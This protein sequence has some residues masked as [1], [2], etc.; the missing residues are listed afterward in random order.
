MLA[1][2]LNSLRSYLGGFAIA[3][4][5][6]GLVIVV[7]LTPVAIFSTHFWIDF[8]PDGSRM[9]PSERKAAIE[10]SFESDFYFRFL[11]AVFGCLALI[12]Y[13]FHEAGREQKGK[14]L[15]EA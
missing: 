1:K 3:L 7:L 4:G 6:I 10:H 2:H 8:S 5:C 12:G 15:T 9:S 13:G 14:L 11:P